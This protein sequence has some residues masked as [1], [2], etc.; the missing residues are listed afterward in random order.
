[1][2]LSRS[3]FSALIGRSVE[4][5][6]SVNLN[7]NGGGKMNL[8]IDVSG[9]LEQRL[10]TEA[11]RQGVDTDVLVR[12]L[13][14]E[15]LGP[16]PTSG[17]PQVLARDLP[18]RDRS[19]EDDWIRSHREDYGG[20]WVALNGNHLI[21]S[22]DDLKRVAQTARELGQADAL[23]VLVESMDALPFAGF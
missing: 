8:T 16:E 14:E 3:G 2:N 22:G 20:Q 11:K 17:L 23:M 7:W 4:A 1:L 18:M 21:A 19:L 5:K 15:S 6:Q 9:D 13:L 10:E 12:H